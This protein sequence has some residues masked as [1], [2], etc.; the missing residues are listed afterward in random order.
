[1]LYRKFTRQR[2]AAIKKHQMK[3]KVV[4]AKKT[5]KSVHSSCIGAFCIYIY[6]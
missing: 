2:K 1:M 4:I 6:I 5:G 3:H